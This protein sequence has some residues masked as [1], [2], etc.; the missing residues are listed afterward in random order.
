MGVAV[1]VTVKDLGLFASLDTEITIGSDMGF[2][3]FCVGEGGG[4][5]DVVPVATSGV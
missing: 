5:A 3:N 4:V 1:G 2:S